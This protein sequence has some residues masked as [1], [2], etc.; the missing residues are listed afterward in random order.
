M[1]DPKL[2]R[3][4]PDLVKEATRVKRVGSPEIVDAWLA[5]DAARR[6]AQARFDTLRAEQNRVGEQVGKLKRELKGQSS[7]ELEALLAS[8][9]GI[10]ETQEALSA[11]RATVAT[12]YFRASTLSITAL[13]CT[14]PLDD[15]TQ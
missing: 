1:L 5:A 10:K 3:E 15:P 8:A 14:D 4:N 9:N 6:N 13:F 12:S 7:P 2:I 11:E